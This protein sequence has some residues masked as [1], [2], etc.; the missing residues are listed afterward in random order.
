MEPLHNP[1]L[2]TLDPKRESALCQRVIQATQE[3]LERPPLRPIT[4]LSDLVPLPDLY[5][6]PPAELD[7]GFAGSH[8]HP[9]LADAWSDWV[10]RSKEVN[11][12]PG[13]RLYLAALH[14]L[15]A[16][17]TARDGAI[18][19]RGSG[20]PVTLLRKP[21]DQPLLRFHMRFSR[22][23]YSPELVSW[24]STP[25][26]LPWSSENEQEDGTIEATVRRIRHNANLNTHSLTYVSAAEEA[27]LLAWSPDAIQD[28]MSKNANSATP[29]PG[30]SAYPHHQQFL[31]AHPEFHDFLDLHS[32][33]ALRSTEEHQLGLR[34]RVR[35]NKA[36]RHW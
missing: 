26:N 31:R 6:Q 10:A 3:Y 15:L 32:F 25:S 16:D 35:Y 23:L 7:R 12:M 14:E 11:Y 20:I 30:S 18:P 27:A 28:W 5:R 2:F 24:M 19:K 13:D 29:F 22:L 36:A 21:L 4:F 9:S 17:L 33:L 34:G 1:Q 8:K